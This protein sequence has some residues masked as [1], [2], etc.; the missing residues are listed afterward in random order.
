MLEGLARDWDDI[1]VDALKGAIVDGGYLSE[2]NVRIPKSEY[3]RYASNLWGTDRHGVSRR[4]DLVVKRQGNADGTG[5]KYALPRNWRKTYGVDRT[6]ADRVREQYGHGRLLK[7]IIPD[8]NREGAIQVRRSGRDIE[9][10]MGSSLDYA[11]RMYEA[12][13]PREGEYWRPG[14]EHGWST[15]R[16]GNRFFEVAYERAQ[17]RMMRHMRRNIE[18]ILR[19]RGML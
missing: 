10:V 19:R 14:V 2:L 5:W 8:G 15:P 4:V 16:T 11:A 7:S 9:M 18:E 6:E 12:T 13:R 3:V 1:A 17:D